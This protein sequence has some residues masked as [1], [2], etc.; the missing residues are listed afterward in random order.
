MIRLQERCRISDHS[1]FKAVRVFDRTVQDVQPCDYFS[2]A[3]CCL[4][5]CS[6][7]FDH[8]YLY[9]EMFLKGVELTKLPGQTVLELTRQQLLAIE[10]RILRALGNSMSTQSLVCS[11][12]FYKKY[13]ELVRHYL[14]DELRLPEKEVEKQ[15]DFGLYLLTIIQFY[16]TSLNEFGARAIAAS[17]V[18]LSLKICNK[19]NVWCSFLEQISGFSKQ[20]LKDVSIKICQKYLDLSLNEEPSKLDRILVVK[21]KFQHERYQSC[22]DIHPQRD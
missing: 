1:W 18:Y 9:A 15:F 16:P 7:F 20:D 8:K 21:L 13:F 10:L 3:A 17:C 11:Y 5:L 4:Y 2:V 12:D 14:R 19:G 6:K 22:S